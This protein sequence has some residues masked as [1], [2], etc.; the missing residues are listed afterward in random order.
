MKIKHALYTVVLK[1]I[2]IDV[3]NVMVTINKNR[4]SPEDSAVH[5]QGRDEG[6]GDCATNY[7]MMLRFH[8]I[9]TVLTKMERTY[10]TSYA[11]III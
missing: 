9:N 11:K 2:T 3:I 4:G 6:Q 10:L 8:K 1:T 7:G 5:T